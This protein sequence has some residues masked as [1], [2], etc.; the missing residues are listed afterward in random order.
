MVCAHAYAFDEPLGGD[1][2]DNPYPSLVEA[3]RDH[4]VYFIEKY[5]LWLVSRYEDIR[6]ILMDPATFSSAN[7]H[8]SLFPTPQSVTDFLAR[9]GYN[10]ASPISASGGDLHKRLRSNVAK[11][12][13]FTP[14]NLARIRVQGEALAEAMVGALPKK[15]EFDIVK[16]LTS[17]YPAHLIYR[18]IGFPPEMDRQMLDWS[19]DRLRLTWSVSSEDEQ[20][21]M[22]AKMVDYWNWCVNFVD[23]NLDNPGDNIAGNFIRIHL[24]DPSRLSKLEVATL[25]FSLVFAGHETTSNSIGQTLRL[26]LE[27]PSRWEAI[28]QDPSRIIDYYNE[29]LRYSPPV[30]AWRRVTTRPVRIGETDVPAGADLLLHFGSGG[31]DERK[32]ED[33][34]NF[35][36]DLPGR[37]GHLAFSQGPHFCIG[38]PLAKLEAEVLLGVLAQRAPDLELV[39]DQEIKVISTISFR[40]PSSLLVRRG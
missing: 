14:S 5:N 39:E 20:L 10:P 26:L 19:M 13:S 8:K 27:V 34:E 24:Q 30:A 22:A 28:K 33:G 12:L 1:F 15:G 7:T 32:F 21:A 3:R 17:R 25:M 37:D 40:G 36:P 6:N 18:L 11:A 4:P 35:R 2:L 16:L 23:E 38:A 9:S 31:H 29:T